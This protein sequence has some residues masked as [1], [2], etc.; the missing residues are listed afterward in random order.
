MKYKVT[1]ITMHDGEADELRALGV[2]ITCTN[3][4]QDSTEF[5]VEPASAEAAEAIR[6]HSAVVRME[7]IAD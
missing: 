6:Q 4:S 5:T 1:A 7:E 3:G 2:P